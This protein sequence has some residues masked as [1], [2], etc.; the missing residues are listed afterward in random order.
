MD[1]QRKIKRVGRIIDGRAGVSFC[2][3]DAKWPPARRTNSRAK[4]AALPPHEAKV[5]IAAA[6]V[7]FRSVCKA[8]R[9]N[10][11]SSSRKVALLHARVVH[12]TYGARVRQA[13]CYVNAIT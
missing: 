6:A 3:A 13:C 11:G 12:V 2:C 5:C 1:K 8:F 7:H 9:T 10:K 4:G